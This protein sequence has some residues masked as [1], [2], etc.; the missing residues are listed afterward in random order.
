M[1]LGKFRIS[2]KAVNEGLAAGRFVH[3]LDRDGNVFTAL[4][5]ERSNRSLC[6]IRKTQPT[7]RSRSSRH[8]GTLQMEHAA[9]DVLETNGSYTA[10]AN[11][12][13]Y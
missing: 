6:K 12:P 10:R 5:T 4:T 7:T 3:Y 13:P 1:E 8:R 2:R 11:L 9:F